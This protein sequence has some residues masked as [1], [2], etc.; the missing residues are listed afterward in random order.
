MATVESVMVL[1]MDE[2]VVRNTTGDAEAPVA[3]KTMQSSQ[4]ACRRTL[5]RPQ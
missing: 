4:Y 1:H 5:Y 3:F 2:K